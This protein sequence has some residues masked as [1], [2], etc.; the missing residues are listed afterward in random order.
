[1]KQNYNVAFVLKLHKRVVL[2]MYYWNEYCFIS[3]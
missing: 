1:L 3:A 2:K